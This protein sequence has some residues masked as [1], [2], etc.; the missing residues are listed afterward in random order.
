MSELVYNTGQGSG[1]LEISDFKYALE[2]GTASL[3]SFAPYTISK[4]DSTYTLDLQ[5]QGYANGDE[6]LTVKPVEKSIYDLAGNEMK[7]L[8]DSNTVYLLESI[9][10]MITDATLAVDNSTVDVTFSEEPFS[11]DNGSGDLEVTDFTFSISGGVATLVSNNPS[12]ITG[13]GKTFTLGISLSTL[14]DGNE[15]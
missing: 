9:P 8:Q 12:T 4:K 15:K 11:T 3:I 14:A 10:P 2:G 13:S 5:V 7:T 6:E 1:E